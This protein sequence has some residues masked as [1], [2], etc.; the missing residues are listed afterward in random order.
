MHLT[1]VER[2]FFSRYFCG[3]PYL[4]YGMDE[5][6]A[7]HQQRFCSIDILF[8]RQCWPGSHDNYEYSS[9]LQIVA[10]WFYQEEWIQ[11]RQLWLE[12]ILLYFWVALMIYIVYLS[13]SLH[14]QFYSLKRDVLGR[15]FIRCL[16]HVL[17]YEQWLEKSIS[18]QIIVCIA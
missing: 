6:L 8:H 18:N 2:F 12:S 7:T 14:H 11:E 16:F 10:E 9:I 3:M 15:T 17:W 4:R 5:S 1:Y 13:F